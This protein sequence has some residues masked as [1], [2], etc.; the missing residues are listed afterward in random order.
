MEQNQKLH[1]T[2]SMP[3]RT[4]F[5]GYVDGIYFRS[6]VGTLGVLPFHEPM[7]T[8]VSDGMLY[9]YVQDVYT[10]YHVN[11]GI[12]QVKEGNQVSISVELLDETS[13]THH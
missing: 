10:Y 1:L 3:E 13:Q 5:S 9:F 4:V 11:H 6:A 7:V 8:L 12:A 2:L